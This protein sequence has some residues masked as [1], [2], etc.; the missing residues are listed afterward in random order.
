MR[1]ISLEAALASLASRN[2]IRTPCT[3]PSVLQIASIE[4]YLP[5]RRLPPRCRRPRRWRRADSQCP[6]ELPATASCPG[7]PPG[8][9]S[10]CKRQVNADLLEFIRECP[11]ASC[12]SNFSLTAPVKA[13]PAE[14][15]GLNVLELLR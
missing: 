7:A 15:M 4:V 14:S 9:F 10:T 1:D 6:L 2:A 13:L 8:S 3:W 5:P 12:L 11:T